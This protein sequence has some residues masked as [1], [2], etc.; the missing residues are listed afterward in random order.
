MRAFARPPDSDSDRNRLKTELKVN[1]LVAWL[2]RGLAVLFA[3]V[4]DVNELNSDKH[5]YLLFAG[6]EDK[7]FLQSLIPPNS[8]LTF[9]APLGEN[10]PDHPFI[11]T[12]DSLPQLKDKLRKFI[13]EWGVGYPLQYWDQQD[14]AV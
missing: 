9:N 1:A 6:E 10:S 12:S 11:Y 2:E 14:T 7:N 4:S 8:T 3:V 5:T 13:L